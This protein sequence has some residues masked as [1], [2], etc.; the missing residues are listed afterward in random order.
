MA[1]FN[2]PPSGRLSRFFKMEFPPRAVVIFTACVLKSAR[3]C[4]ADPVAHG[5][6]VNLWTA[7]HSGLKD[8][9][10]LLRCP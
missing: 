6:P 2:K 8:L 5:V 9:F 10:A 7:R 3:E 4:S 1:V